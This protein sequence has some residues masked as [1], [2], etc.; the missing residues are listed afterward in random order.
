MADANALIEASRE[1]TCAHNALYWGRYLSD[2]LRAE[3]STRLEQA[4]GA[5]VR[6]AHEPQ[7][8]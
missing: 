2:E 5:L 4:L 6:V 7:A 1:V 3:A 8:Q